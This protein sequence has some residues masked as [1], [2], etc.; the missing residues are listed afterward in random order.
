MRGAKPGGE[1][2]LP[3][4]CFLALGCLLSLLPICLLGCFPT[5][6][7]CLLTAVCP[8]AWCERSTLPHGTGP[9]TPS[10][11]ML[12]N[13]DF[14]QQYLTSVY[15]ALT[16]LMKTAHIGPDTLYEKFFACVHPLMRSYK[17]WMLTV[18]RW[19]SLTAADD[20]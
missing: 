14:V 6:P 4:E 7:Y 9:L 3:P 12:I 5:A 1:H 16:M 8:L 13:A 10:P 20:R 19:S 11:A 17:H 18:G 2:W 15:W